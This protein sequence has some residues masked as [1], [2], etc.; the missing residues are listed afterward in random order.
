[1]TTYCRPAQRGPDRLHGG[2]GPGRPRPVDAAR[3]TPTTASGS[4]AADRE[5]ATSSGDDFSLEYRMLAQGRADGVGAGRGD[6]RS[7][8]EDDRRYW[9]GFMLDI[10]ERK[11]AEERSRAPSSVEREATQRLRAARRDE[12]HLPAGGLPRPPDAARRDPRPRDHARTRPTSSLEPEETHE[13]A[14]GSPRTRA[15]STGW[16]PT[17][18]ISTGSRG[19]SSSPSCTSIDVGDARPAGASSESGPARRG[20]RGDWTCSR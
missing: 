16:S 13:L 8:S 10:T 17:C 2:G 18:W 19:A 3:S 11:E 1:M 6:A 7:R 12:E 20:A 4:R 15:S 14:A 9:Q 5:H